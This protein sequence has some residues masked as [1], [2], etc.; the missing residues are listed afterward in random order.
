[1]VQ[2]VSQNRKAGEVFL[3]A[4][5][6]TAKIAGIAKDYR[7]AKAKNLPW[8]R[9]AQKIQSPP[10]APFLCVSKVLLCFIW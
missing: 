8:K 2:V 9:E 7:K 6:R 10:L 5:W 4:P 1:M 3:S